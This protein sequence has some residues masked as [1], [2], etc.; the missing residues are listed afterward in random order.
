MIKS[1]GCKINPTRKLNSPW[2]KWKFSARVIVLSALGQGVDQTL[3]HT[4]SL[5]P[6]QEPESTQGKRWSL[7]ELFQDQV[8]DPGQTSV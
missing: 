7:S 5:E 6:D 1:P 3:H 4:G 8:V 2:R